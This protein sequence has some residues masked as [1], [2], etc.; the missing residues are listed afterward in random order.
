[1]NGDKHVLDDV[2]SQMPVAHDARSEIERGL[3]VTVVKRGK[4]GVVA[5]GD[6]RQKAIVRQVDVV[7]ASQGARVSFA[8]DA[9]K[10]R[11]W[12]ENHHNIDRE[13]RETRAS[14]RP[15]QGVCMRSDQNWPRRALSALWLLDGALQLQPFMFTRGFITQVIE[16]AAAGQPTFLHLAITHAA[17]LLAPHIAL[18]N[19]A[20][21]LT[22]ITIGLGLL[23][24]RTSRI[25]LIASIAWAAN[26][27]ILG[28]GLGGLLTGNANPITGAPGAALLYL[29][30]SLLLLPEL[31]QPARAALARTCWTLLWL[32]SALLF[33]QPANHTTSATTLLGGVATTHP[34]TTA[35]LL[36][37]TSTLIALGIHLPRATQA[38]LIAGSV[39]SITYWIYGQS[40]TD[41]TTGTATDPNSG[42]LW[43]LLAATTAT[44]IAKPRLPRPR[45]TAAPIL[46]PQIV[47]AP[48]PTASRD[49]LRPVV[50][51]PKAAR[52]RWWAI[53]TP[54]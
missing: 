30:V 31:G 35:T 36:A 38:A 54:G 24:T 43:I 32:T 1:M 48:T 2:L 39:L 13:R 51:C 52:T 27:W 19:T 44:T 37:A 47:Q 3:T 46:K 40:P 9:P 8:A 34:T 42:P 7:V 50:T 16:P 33:L 5:A 12:M 29:V 45:P 53:T 17:A 49:A 6:Q 15:N 21:A 14:A 23:H 18:W 11:Q 26:V 22:Q 41:L 10:V 4:R 25:A 28:E 20:F